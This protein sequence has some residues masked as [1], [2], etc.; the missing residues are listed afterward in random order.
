MVCNIRPAL[1]RAPPLIILFLMTFSSANALLKEQA[2]KYDWLKQNIGDI[3]FARIQRDRIFVASR[4]GAI[5]A[6]NPADGSIAWRVLLDKGQEATGLEA[7][8]G[9]AVVLTSSGLLRAFGPQGQL[10]WEAFL[11]GTDL[12]CTGQAGLGL[13]ADG[14]T[15]IVG[16]GEAV[17]AFS[18]NNGRR[19][20]RSALNGPSYGTSSVFVSEGTAT[21]AS[22][23][24]R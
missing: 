23:P 15:I 11:P 3:K 21:V 24:A 19:D 2:G 14:N 16:C 9:V 8:A 20:W 1:R 13:T 6:L 10:Q 22:I 7:V 5:A 17:G 4:A 18:V 12:G